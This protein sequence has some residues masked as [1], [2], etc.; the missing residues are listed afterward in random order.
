MTNDELK[1]R[2]TYHPPKD[3]QPDRYVSIRSKAL[4]LALLINELTPESRE[5]SIAYTE[6]DMVVFFANSAIARNE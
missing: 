4:E 5:Q 1:H 3:D 6:L 2:F